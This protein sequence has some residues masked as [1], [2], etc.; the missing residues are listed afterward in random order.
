MDS[1]RVYKGYAVADVSTPTDDGRYRARA[2]IMSLASERTRSQRFIDLEVYRTLEQAQERSMAA[3]IAWI[4]A[5]ASEDRL[6]LPT[7]FSP[8]G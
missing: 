5:P 3:A 1:R 4:D 7:N 8:L 2:A 6:A